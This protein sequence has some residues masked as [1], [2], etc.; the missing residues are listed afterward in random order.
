MRA[1]AATLAEA[2]AGLRHGTALPRLQPR[3]HRA[4]HA[5]GERLQVL[6]RLPGATSAGH[7]ASLPWFTLAELQL[8]EALGAGLSPK[9]SYV[10]SF[11]ELRRKP[12][13]KT[14]RDRI[15]AALQAQAHGA[16]PEVVGSALKSSRKA[17][18]K[19]IRFLPDNTQIEQPAT[20]IR[21]LRTTGVT[22]LS[23]EERRK[24]QG[25]QLGVPDSVLEMYFSM[26]VPTYCELDPPI[27]TLVELRD[28]LAPAKP[29]LIGLW[30]VLK[31]LEAAAVEGEWLL[32]QRPAYINAM[33]GVTDALVSTGT[34]PKELSQDVRSHP[35]ALP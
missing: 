35:P 9:K 33:C 17:L 8:E 5:V 26:L 2:Q 15:A 13:W 27:S 6:G 24:I 22:A 19:T 28:W 3:W 21:A 29:E 18:L 1:S 34:L 30:R 20:K 10:S 14:Q 12:E 16:A 11:E 23:P 4:V 32:P 7:V 25:G 31:Q